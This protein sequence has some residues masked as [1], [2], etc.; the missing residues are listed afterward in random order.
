MALL[1]KTEPRIW[2]RPLRKLTEK[3]SLGF[4]AIEYAETVLGMHLTPWEEWALIHILEI[5]GDL[6]KSWR[7]RFRTVLI[8]VSRQNGKTTLSKVIASFFLNVLK[9][10]NV[11]GTSLSMDKAEEVWEAVIQDQETH[12]DLAAEIQQVARRNG[13]KRLVLKCKCNNKFIIVKQNRFDQ[14]VDQAFAVF[15]NAYI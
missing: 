6:R 2:T 8:L 3:T 9:V 7:F 14:A 1:G 13:G 10:E 15:R 4:A 5:V 12:P 11:F